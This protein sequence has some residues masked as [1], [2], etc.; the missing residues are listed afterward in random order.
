MKLSL[1]N[2]VLDRSGLTPVT[3]LLQGLIATLAQAG[4]GTLVITPGT[5]LTG[6]LVLPSNFTLHLEAGA[7]LQ[8]R[9]ADGA[10]D[11]N[12]DVPDGSPVAAGSAR[13]GTDARQ[14]PSAE[15]PVYRRSHF[16]R[17]HSNYGGGASSGAGNRQVPGASEGEVA[18]RSFM[19]S[20]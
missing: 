20:S 17:S 9:S 5:Y 18:W 8:R 3:D 6:T 13:R 14:L 1:E 15:P 7:R 2:V 10:G 11:A 4:G 19:L 12:C 16:Y